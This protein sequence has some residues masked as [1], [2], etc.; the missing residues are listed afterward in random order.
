M[1]AVA[2][3]VPGRTNNQCCF[4]WV[5]TLDRANRKN[6][7]QWT[8]EEDTK[9]REAVKKHGKNWVAIAEMVPGRTER[10]CRP[11]WTQ[12]LDP[13]SGDKG[14]WKAEEDAMLKDAVEKHGKDWAAIAAMVPGRTNTQCRQRWTQALDPA[15]W[16][17]T[18][19]W[20]TE[21]DTKL[22]KAVKI[23]VRDWVAVTKLV[24]GRTNYCCCKRWARHLDPDRVPRTS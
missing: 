1:V 18:G 3:L 21:E 4:R 16:K 11:R 14:K 5:Y 6:A 20:T 12:A 22:K 7:G 2:T 19:K 10:Q 23:H 24:P 17:K 9:L 15:N 13:A 8:P